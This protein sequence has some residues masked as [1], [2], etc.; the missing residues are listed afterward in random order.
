L[1]R[2]DVPISACRANLGGTSDKVLMIELANQGVHV[3]AAK[4]TRMLA[5]SVRRDA[6]RSSGLTLF[7]LDGTWG[8]VSLFEQARGVFW[9]WPHL[10]AQAQAGPQGSAWTVPLTQNVAKLR[11]TLAAAQAGTGNTAD[12]PTSQPER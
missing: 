2:D 7:L 9:W 10:V 1:K 3:L 8:N 6:W 4:D 5:A 12:A 11:R